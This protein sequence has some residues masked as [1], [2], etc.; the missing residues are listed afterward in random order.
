MNW[1]RLNLVTH[2]DVGYFLSGLILVYCASGLA[3]NHVDDWNPDFMVVKKTVTVSRAYQR[4]EVTQ[5]VIARFGQLVGE[6]KWKVYDFPTDEKVKIYYDNASLLVDLPSRTG[7]YE[8][9]SRRPM[10]FQANV[11]HRNSVRGWRWAADAFAVALIVLN[12]TGL[13]VLRGRNG[14]FGRGKWFIAAGV[15]PPIFALAAFEFV[16]R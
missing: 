16:Q 13:I 8:S 15:L 4:P 9:V 7:V 1:R 2:R 14:F 10:V 11:L 3:L 12:I 6:T 5:E